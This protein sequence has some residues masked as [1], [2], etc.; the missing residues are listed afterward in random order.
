MARNKG[1]IQGEL[2]EF[3]IASDLVEN[4]CRVSYTHG[5]YPYDMIADLDAELFK[6][7]V[8]TANKVKNRSNKYMIRTAK[9][10]AENVDLFAG[11]VPE[12]DTVFYVRFEDAGQNASVTYT[13]RNELSEHNASTAKFGDEHTF[14]EVVKQ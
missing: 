10:T 5:D 13:G 12:R 8:K 2:S 11:Y 7:Q 6:V 9:Y 4:G 14:E 1:H 3:K